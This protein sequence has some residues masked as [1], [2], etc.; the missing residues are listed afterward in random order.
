M[1]PESEPELTEAEWVVMK[2]I[3][4]SEPC[5]APQIQELLFPET[6]W[7]YSTVRTLMDRLVGK[8]LL[9]SE[10]S[11]KLTLYRSVA[12]RSQAQRGELLYALK[13]AFNNAVTPL[14]ECLL[15]AQKISPTELDQLKRLLAQ[16]EA[17]ST[18]RSQLPTPTA[19]DASPLP[20]NSATE[21]AES[22]DRRHP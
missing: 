19:T 2:K 18:P 3:W 21:G 12:T 13:N 15:G 9:K 4:D 1:H 17:N 6:R 22:N 16:H 10:K 8:G 7:T 5:T 11:G 14:M 20:Q